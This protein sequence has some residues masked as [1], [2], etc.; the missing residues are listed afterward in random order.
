MGKKLKW[1]LDGIPLLYCSDVSFVF[2]DL[3]PLLI[4]RNASE[5]P[6]ADL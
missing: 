6:V 3:C 5:K 1:N 4:M 2:V